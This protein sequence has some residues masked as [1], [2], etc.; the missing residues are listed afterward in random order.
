MRCR[1]PDCTRDAQTPESLRCA[2][3]WAAGDILRWAQH[4]AVASIVYYGA[5]EY[6]PMMSDAEFDGRCAALLAASAW[7]QIPWLEREMLIAGSGYILEK[8]P[9]D[10]WEAAE[11]WR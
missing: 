2:D 6:G 5:F 7:K 10:L 8:F 9:A 11:H 4:Y 1:H 3:H